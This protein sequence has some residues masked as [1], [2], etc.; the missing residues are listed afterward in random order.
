VI[1]ADAPG[2]TY[3][4]YAGIY[5]RATKV[6]WPAQQNG[7]AAHDDLLYLGTLT[8]PDLPPQ[9][10]HSYIPLVIREQ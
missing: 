7:S 10:Y 2:G 3:T 8:L 9:K 6:R 1:P 5:D 4:L